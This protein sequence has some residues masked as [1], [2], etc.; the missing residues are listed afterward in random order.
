MLPGPRSRQGLCGHAW[1]TGGDM[2]SVYAHVSG[3]AD[4][5]CLSP[6]A[7]Q[8]KPYP[9]AIVNRK[10]LLTM[11]GFPGNHLSSSR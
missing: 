9:F 10:G 3:Q 6:L 5:G 4:L 8:L 1:K 7:L 2:G 11:G